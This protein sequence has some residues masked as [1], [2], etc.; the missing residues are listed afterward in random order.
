NVAQYSTNSGSAQVVLGIPISEW[1]SVSAVVGIDSNEILSVPGSTP[2]EF[3]DYLKAVGRRTFHAWRGQFAWARDT[4]NDY[5]M[6]SRGSYQRVSP[7]LALPGSTVEYYTL[8]YEYS[9]YSPLN[10]SLIL[11]TGV[12]LGFGDSYGDPIVRD[13]CWTR[14]TP[15]TDVNPNPPPP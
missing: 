7:E 5:F 4:R 2:E 1:D 9:R 11:R 3:N 15:P 14:P 13:I 10:P 6:P 12:N 8:E